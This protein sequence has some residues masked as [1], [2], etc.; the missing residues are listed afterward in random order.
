[1]LKK[2]A[3]CICSVLVVAAVICL[4]VVLYR[5]FAQQATDS[6]TLYNYIS[7]IEEDHTGVGEMGAADN[8]D[9]SYAGSSVGYSIGDGVGSALKDYLQSEG[10]SVGEDTSPATSQEETFSPLGT[11][12]YF[13]YGSLPPYSGDPYIAV[14]NGM[15]WFVSSNLTTNSYEYYGDLDALGR[16]TVAYACVGADIM[17]TEERGEIGMIRPSGWHTAKYPDVIEDMYL[18]NRC[19]LLMYA[20]T[21]E[22]ANEKNLITGTRY[23]NVSG[24]LPYE[25]NIL[26][27]IRQ[28]GNHVLY[29]VTP[30]FVGDE[31][32]CRG[33]LM[34]AYSVEDSG[35]GV[36]F[37]TFCYNVQ[38]G[39]Q[40][41]YATGNSW[42]IDG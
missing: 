18:Y 4:G 7:S 14:N 8:S 17:P 34:E 23:L 11:N 6:A 5:S 29:R 30:I 37:C 3:V 40:I 38:P 26:S 31:L 16:C 10:F 32:V 9:Q 22:N 42:K 24:M 1:M 35:R 20:L 15:P 41:D 13:D 27:Y 25:D 28:T 36:C 2:I 33:V 19:H 39:I 12:S 21:G